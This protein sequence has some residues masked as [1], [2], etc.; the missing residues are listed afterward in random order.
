MSRSPAPVLAYA[1]ALE[2]AALSLDRIQNTAAAQM[3]ALL[4]DILAARAVVQEL[5]AANAALRPEHDRR[6]ADVA[7]LAGEATR[8]ETALR[9]VTRAR[10]L[11]RAHAVAAQALTPAALA[12]PADPA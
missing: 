10:S 11:S 6:A 7:R 1:A 9:D 2:R 4:V 5:Q 3:D 8:Y 12:Q